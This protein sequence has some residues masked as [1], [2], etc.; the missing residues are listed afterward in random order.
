MS[1]DLAAGV[2]LQWKL[3]A[4][5]EQRIEEELYRHARTARELLVF[6]LGKSQSPVEWTITQVD[7]I[8]DRLGDSMAA[9]PAGPVN[10]SMSLS[11]VARFV[12]PRL[13]GLTRMTP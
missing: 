2:Y 7:P 5:Q 13:S 4:T 6:D 8:T 3:R 9:R 12:R 11:A 10:Q 1:V